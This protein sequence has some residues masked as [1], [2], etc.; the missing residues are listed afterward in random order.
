MDCLIF[1]YFHIFVG[2]YF[3]VGVTFGEKGAQ[4]SPLPAFT[5]AM[6]VQRHTILYNLYNIFIS[7]RHVYPLSAISVANIISFQLNNYVE[8]YNLTIYERLIKSDHEFNDC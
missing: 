8:L 4:H 7:I 3:G 6:L 2:F 5:F 1:L